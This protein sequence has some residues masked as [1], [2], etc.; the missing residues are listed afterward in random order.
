MYLDVCACY[1]GKKDIPLIIGGRYGL[2]S[3][4]TVPADI[5][6]TYKNLDAKEP[7]HGF[8]LAICDDVTNLSLPRE[9]NPDTSAAGN[10]ACK[11]W[12]CTDCP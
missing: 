7:V 3:K 2:G 9:E 4:D 8:T 6:A 5:I 10:T 12:G 11:F 1:N